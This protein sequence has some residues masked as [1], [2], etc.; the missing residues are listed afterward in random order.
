MQGSSSSDFGH[1]FLKEKK[2]EQVNADH[3]QVSVAFAA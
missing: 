2:G 3:F 1:Y